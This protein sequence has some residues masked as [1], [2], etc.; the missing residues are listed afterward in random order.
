LGNK[1]DFKLKFCDY[2][3]HGE[4]EL[5]EQMTQY[6]IQKN[7]PAKLLPYLKCFL[8]GSTGDAAE[9][10]ACV[11]SV[12]VSESKL[13]TCVAATDKQFKVKASFADKTT[14]K[15][16]QFPPFDVFAADNQ[17]YGVQGSPT[18]VINGETI[19]SSRDSASL[20]KTICSG[21]ETEPGECQAQLSAA[22]P[23]A[24]FGYA[25]GGTATDATCN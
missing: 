22:S 15:S 11:K 19:S 8:G 6:C 13:K 23:S 18:L 20:L 9:S 7:E 16:G 3:M 4:K 14:W 5:A 2:A 21:F 25:T 24:G 12:K 10:A 17:K 1:V